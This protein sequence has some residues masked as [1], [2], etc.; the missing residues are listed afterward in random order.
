VRFPNS[1]VADAPARLG[2]G[3]AA[4]FLFP[5]QIPIDPEHT[6]EQLTS[7]FRSLRDGLPELI[8]NAKDQYSRL[9]VLDRASRQ[10]VVI[11]D[12]ETRR[13]GV[14]DFAGARAS[15]FNGW[16]TWSSRTAGRSE[17]SE[18]IEAGHGNGGKAFMVRGATEVAFLESCFEGKRTRMGFENNRAAVRYKPGYARANSTSLNNV[19]EPDPD[20]RLQALLAELGISTST[21]PRGL[22]AAFQSRRA[23]TAVLLSRVAEW[24]GRQKRKVK[25]LAQE[26]IPDVIASHGQAALSIETCDVWVIVDGEL[27]TSSPIKPVALVPYPG[28]EEPIQYQIPDLLPDPETGDL[29]NMLEGTEGPRFLKLCTSVRQLQMSEETKARNVIRIWNSRNNVANWPLHSLGVLVTSVSFIYG[30]IRCPALVGDHLAGAERFYLSNTPLVR[31]LKEW[32]CQKVKEI[33]DE[34]HQAMMAESRP[35]DREQAK[36]ALQN[37]R[38]LMR[39]Y[40]D[41]DASGDS[42]DDEE[43]DYGPSG[44]NDGGSKRKRKGAKFGERLDEIVLEPGRSN[45]AL[46]HGTSVPIRFNCLEHQSDGSQKPVRAADLRLNSTMLETVSLIDGHRLAG[47]A[48]GQGEIWLE[49]NDGRVS[50]NKV[51]CEVIPA[52]DV[53]ITIPAEVLLQG[54]RLKLSV[55]FHTLNGPRDDL[56]IDGAIDEPGMGLLGRHGRFTAGF[57]EG[58]ATIR[59]RFGSA[60]QHQRATTIHIGSERVPIPDS[61]V[62]RGTDIPDILLCGE[63]APGMEEFAVEQRTLPGGEELPTIIEDPLFPN[64]V[65]INPTSKESTRVRRSRGGPS[66]VGSIASKNFMHFVALK[67]FDVLKRLHVRQALRGRTITEFEFIQLTAFAEIE[68]ADFIDAAWEMSDQMLGRAEASGVSAAA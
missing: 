8:K 13:L 68:C 35:R 9:G 50:S 60:P 62:S 42:P 11:A 7:L 45:I 34:L 41:P 53:D 63:E 33:A 17:L 24:E 2:R 40:L 29:I 23:F 46:A 57:K 61:E 38:N 27:I 22:I 64:I 26:M 21:L 47:N 10:I 3:V 25:R 59:V 4:E 31:A 5:D 49:T 48:V 28:F 32:T 19:D 14:I 56:L 36:A 18:D 44:E 54:Q 66:G 37:I 52:T 12:T 30:E 1:K 51:R 65:W 67:C 39:Q 16:T 20:G 58:Q 6:L 55:T 43:R 15:D